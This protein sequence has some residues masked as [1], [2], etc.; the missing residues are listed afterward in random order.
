MATDTS[1]TVALK[2]RL[3]E[4][5]IRRRLV[6][7]SGTAL[8]VLYL[9]GLVTW[10]QVAALLVLGAAVAL[11][12]EILRLRVGLDWAIY[13]HLTREYERD[14]LAGYAFYVFSSAAVAVAAIDGTVVEP[15]VAAAAILMLT[16]GDPISGL[17]ESGGGPNS[18]KPP[19]ALA[20]MFLVCTAIALPLVPL[21]VA[22]FGGFAGMV[23]DGVKPVVAGFVLDDNLTIPPTAALAMQ[24]GLE[25]LAL[26]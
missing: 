1:R 4:L 3:L 16:L 20:A 9:F 13:E 26:V 11:A 21:P 24:T 6:H 23:A 25:I 5:E 10:L 7:A 12:L 8:P 2:Q 17:I 15:R 19:R 18:I 14:S 22:V